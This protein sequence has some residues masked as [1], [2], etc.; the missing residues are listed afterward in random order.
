VFET[1]S[2]MHTFRSRLFR[3]A[4]EGNGTAWHL[5][6]YCQSG[7]D[8]CGLLMY[9]VWCVDV[10]G[11]TSKSCSKCGR[12][13]VPPKRDRHRLCRECNTR[14]IH[15]AP[16][17]ITPVPPLR[18][19][20]P[21]EELQSTQQFKRRRL[22]YT[23]LAEIGCPVSALKP[24][25]PS[26]HKLLHLTA[27]VRRRMRTVPLL[28]IPSEKK[29]TLCKR[30]LA[31]SAGTGTAKFPKG[32]YIKD[33]LRFVSSIAAAS[34]VIAVG[35]DTG[36]GHTK[37]GVTYLVD[38]TLEFAALLVYD[39]TDN[40][41]QLTRLKTP[42]ITPFNGD[43]EGHADIFS[44]LQSLI[45]THSA[46]L[47]GDWLFLNVIT[48]LKSA[49]A[50]NPC[51]ICIVSTV[52]LLRP[53][54]Y[55]TTL[56]K[57]SRLHPPLLRVESDRIVPTP[58]HV[59]LGI[60]NRVI[61]QVYPK[62]F[63]ES[64]VMESVTECRTIHSAGNG[65]LA[66]VHGL[67][68]PEIS[69][70]LKKEC[71]ANVWQKASCLRRLPASIGT[72]MP[73]LARWMDYLHTHLLRVDEWTPSQITEYQAFIR[74]IHRNWQSTTQQYPFPKL[75]MLHHTAEFAERYRFLGRVGESQIESYHAQFNP[76]FHVQHR[77]QSRNP[78][79]RLRRCLADMAV[80][81]L[82]TRAKKKQKGR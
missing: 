67:N 29:I 66:D 36:G 59:Y 33:P 65:G 22:A 5:R 48:G 6:E 10:C 38:G 19:K 80:S 8:H 47:N 69:R 74:D 72:L 7:V 62:L 35:G 42:G 76:L 15:P 25:P 73:R 34:P 32:A 44:V 61:M 52:D 9:F 71:C 1:S 2:D 24:I 20:R 31:E 30:R 26:P 16:P 14:R 13:Y 75:H 41:E 77:N 78:E 57:H 45:D 43:S 58:L 21:Y 12:S 17:I 63:G 51:P 46:F 4:V 37:L 23:A 18:R 64:T 70:W 40:W 39:G 79:E 11:L 50:T 60:C 49:S 54:R 56:D 27:A 55:R 68:G 82:R 28:T 81:A 53:A 3:D